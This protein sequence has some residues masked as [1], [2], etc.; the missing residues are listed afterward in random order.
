MKTMHKPLV[1]ALL[2]V[3]LAGCN[4]NNANEP[5]GAANETGS[6]LSDFARCGVARTSTIP[7]FRSRLPSAQRLLEAWCKLPTERYLSM[8]AAACQPSRTARNYDFRFGSFRD[9]LP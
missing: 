8:N 5:A 4:K 6:A 2:I 9:K 3:G 7:E 1:A